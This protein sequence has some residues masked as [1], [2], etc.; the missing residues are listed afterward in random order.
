MVFTCVIWF[1]TYKLNFDK[2]SLMEKILL[3]IQIYSV[4]NSEMRSN[5]KLKYILNNYTKSDILTKILVVYNLRSSSTWWMTLLVFHSNNHCEWA[6]YFTSCKC[7]NIIFV[8]LN[9]RLGPKKN[10]PMQ[11]CS[12]WNFELSIPRLML[13]YKL[14][15]PEKKSFFLRREL[16]IDLKLFDSAILS[17]PWPDLQKKNDVKIGWFEQKIILWSYIFFN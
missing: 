12:I 11:L 17:P 14:W 9:L 3:K 10:T 1:L 15:T 7:Q 4:V 5:T 6:L 16:I 8:K 2:L 13:T